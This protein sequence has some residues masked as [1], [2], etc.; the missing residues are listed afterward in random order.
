MARRRRELAVAAVLAVAFT[1]LA[2]LTTLPPGAARGLPGDLAVNTVAATDPALRVA[3]LTVTTAGSPAAVDI[4]T[5]IAVIAIWA[6]G[7]RA[8][9]VHAALYL[10]AARLLEL[11]IETAVKHLTN[12]HRPMIP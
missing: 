3:A 9:R 2:V 6:W 12:R 4:L 11:G 10:V 7:A 5:G 8:W 1:V